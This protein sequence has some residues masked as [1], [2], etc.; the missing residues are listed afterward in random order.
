MC[1]ARFMSLQLATPQTLGN[2][3]REFLFVSIGK[4]V[5]QRREASLADR[6]ESFLA[7]PVK[8]WARDAGLPYD[9]VP[10]E[11]IASYQLPAP[12]EEKAS[13]TL[14]VTASFG[15]LIP[16]SIL[17]R[18]P[19]SQRLNLHPSLLPQLSGAAPIQ[20]AIARQM[21]STGVSVQSLG[22]KF[23]SGHIYAQEEMVRFFIANY[24]TMVGRGR[25]LMLI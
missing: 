16:S 2:Q 24:W 25:S 11:G 8:E 5:V 9:T 22:E 21:K 3:K 7:A 23:D 12:F 20:W 18:F 17:S 14:L 6:R 4:D 10:A 1:A 13:D 15:H 19:A